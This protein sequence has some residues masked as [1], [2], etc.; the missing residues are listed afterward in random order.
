MGKGEARVGPSNCGRLLS[1]YKCVCWPLKM[2][3][4]LV[5][6]VIGRVRQGNSAFKGK[7]PLVKT[8]KVAG[9]LFPPTLCVCVPLAR[10]F[11]RLLNPVGLHK[12][13][14]I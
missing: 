6:F 10:D 14:P 12:W 9:F 5:A 2:C 8:A 4:L 13:V 11:T 7:A 1:P 3:P